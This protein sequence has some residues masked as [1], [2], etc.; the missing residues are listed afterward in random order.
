MSLNVISNYAANVAQRYLQKSDA[1][2]TRSLAK[3]AAGTRTLSARD[4]AASLA[5]GTKF[6]A[7]V[8]SLATAAVNIGQAASMLQI[9]DGALGTVSDT[10]ARMKTLAGQSMSGQLT[11]SERAM[12]NAEFGQLK[13]ELERTA[14]STTFNGTKLISANEARQAATLDTDDVADYLFNNTD[15]GIVNLD[16]SK[17]NQGDMFGL[18]YDSTGKTFTLFNLTTGEGESVNLPDDKRGD[19]GDENEPRKLVSFA[20][21]GVSFQLD[22]NFDSSSDLNYVN[23]GAQIGLPDNQRFRPVE[24]L[25]D[26]NQENAPD[27]AKLNR[28]KISDFSIKALKDF[29]SFA[30][31]DLAGLAITVNGDYSISLAYMSDMT[32][33]ETSMTDFD[34]VTITVVSADGTVSPL[35]AQVDELENTL[36]SRENLKNGDRATFVVHNNAWDETREEY[37]RVSFTIDDVS[38]LDSVADDTEEAVAIM[39]M[40]V[41]GIFAV[42][43]NTKKDNAFQFQIGATSSM[44]D[45]MN[46]NIDIVDMSTLGL[47]DAYIGN[48][49]DAQ[50]SLISLEKAV[51]KVATS[52][53]NLGASANR[54]EFAA[55][56]VAS[57]KENLEA[58]R[59][60]LMDLDV[61][62]EM[63]Y[64]TS[65]QIL[66]QAGVSM[67]AQANQMPQNLLRLFR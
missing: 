59:S 34:G 19:V 18:N 37:F 66:Q 1:D 60:S 24:Y 4:D 21:L 63:S 2:A 30:T 23:A 43:A 20:K 35:S 47:T 10:L 7:D 14:S 54:I 62:A 22:E 11:Q 13:M 12:L 15:N 39:G 8:A 16:V 36:Q 44:S 28:L 17:A 33:D 5:V 40:D 67:L 38:G 41:N 65:Q 49:Y 48:A 58:A 53:A 6:K 26:A 31:D 9:A 55:A 32:G 50:Q 29:A 25:K 57:M 45:K 52:R 42:K 51:T 64:F 46:V 61:A 56:N 3:L 27:S